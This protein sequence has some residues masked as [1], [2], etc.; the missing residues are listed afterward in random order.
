MRCVRKLRALRKSLLPKETSPEISLQGCAT[1][2]RRRLRGGSGEGGGGERQPG[3]I[4]RT[5]VPRLAHSRNPDL[6]ARFG[7]IACCY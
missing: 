2:L 6:G 7:N 4:A 5:V 3:K 1:P